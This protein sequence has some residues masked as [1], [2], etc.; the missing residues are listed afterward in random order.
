MSNSIINDELTD[1]LTN[2]LKELALAIS[3]QQQ[4]KLLEYVG[5]LCKWNKTYNLTA[6]REPE[7]MIGLHILDSL[8]VLP[9]LNAVNIL[10]V[11]TGGG[12]P[13]IPLAIARADSSVTMLDSL[14]KKTT[15]VRQAITELGLKNAWVVCERVEHY[16][17]LAKFDLV[18]S[19]AFAELSDF[20]NSAAHTV[21]DS[22][23]FFAMKG[24]Y[25]HDEI[26]RLPAT[27]KVEQVIELSVPQIEG[28]RHL[29]VLKK[30]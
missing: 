4:E 28:K 21:V 27:H 24:V 26:A 2:G 3:V 16:Q 10:D 18:I 7:K 12:L 1:L 14:Q 8:A 19:R 6:V 15:F 17:P 9:Y 13:G 25:P 30:A 29:V 22:G 20:I 11:G 5:L 23:R